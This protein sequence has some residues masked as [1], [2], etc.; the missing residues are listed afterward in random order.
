MLSMKVMII[1]QAIYSNTSMP[2]LTKGLDAYALRDK[3]TANNLAN[4]NTPK[5]KKIKVDFEVELSK[6]LDKNRLRGVRTDREHLSVGRKEISEVKPRA[7][8]SYDVTTPG[9]INNVDIDMEM[10]QMAENQLSFSYAT[11]MIK[12]LMDSIKASI[13]S[14]SF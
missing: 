11:S 14:R 3:A 6:S 4:V 5:Y 2:V 12:N 13:R 7:S 8:R 1:K 9:E 10:A